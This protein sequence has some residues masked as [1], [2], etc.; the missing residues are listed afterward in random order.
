MWKNTC[1]A[2]LCVLATAL[3]L[4]GAAAARAQT[5]SQMQLVEKKLVAERTAVYRITQE[6]RELGREEIT[7]RTYNTNTVVYEA[8]ISLQHT[9]DAGYDEVT[10]LELEEDSHFP[11]AFTMKR[12]MHHGDMQVEHSVA[13]E[14]FTNLA[15]IETHLRESSERYHVVV[16]SGSTIMETGALHVLEPLL[17]IYSDDVGGSQAVQVFDALSRRV[18]RVVVQ[19]A[20]SEDVTVGGQTVSAVVYTVEREKFPIKLFV[21]GEHRVVR[22]EM[23]MMVYDLVSWERRP[24]D[25][26]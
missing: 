5:R 26:K 19:R 11:R 3:A 14:M 13:V 12:D 8:R 18:E 15:V 23:N 9:E 21:D 22:C 6:G 10:R 24:G 1:N 16:P 17:A 7:V 25:A 4:S 20:G 2:A